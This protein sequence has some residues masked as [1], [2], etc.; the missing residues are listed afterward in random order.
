MARLRAEDAARRHARADGADF[1]EALARGI[2]VVTAFNGERRQ[3]T[4]SDVARATDLPKASV[5]R[6]L[7]TLAA[8]GYVES[9]GR[10]FRLAPKVLTLASA[11]LASNAVSSVVQPL[12]ER[13]AAEFSEACSAAV[14]DRDDIVMVA[15][16]SPPRF[17]AVAP[18]VGFRLPAYCTALGRVLLAALSEAALEAY[19]ERLQPAA[20]TEHT[21]TDKRRLRQAIAAVRADGFAFADQEAEL[22]FRSVAVPLRRYDGVVIAALNIGTRIERASVETMLGSHLPRLRAD[23][24]TLQALL[25]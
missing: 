22:G 18:G 14:L 9:D 25:V 6:A 4:L 1:L 21:I 16:A 20:Q 12:C 19:L 8:L 13:L 11:Y 5:R 17:A 10:L 3:M 15:H 2:S 7:H 23:A 24:A